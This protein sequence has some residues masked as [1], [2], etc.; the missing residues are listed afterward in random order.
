MSLSNYKVVPYI[1]TTNL[2]VQLYLV[3]LAKAEAL[4]LSTKFGKRL[5][6]INQI[7]RRYENQHPKVVSSI[8]RLRNEIKLLGKGMPDRE[9]IAVASGV[10]L[11]GQQFPSYKGRVTRQ[12][13]VQRGFRKL[14]QTYHP[15]K[16][17]SVEQFN[18]LMVARE[19]LDLDWINQHLVLQVLGSSIAWQLEQGLPFWKLQTQRYQVRFDRIAE[20]PAFNVVQLHMVGRTAEASSTMLSILEK[21]VVALTA[22][23][24]ASIQQ[25]FNHG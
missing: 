3:S 17:G 9:G 14:A 11:L 1:D 13:L 10:D 22:E 2:I 15:D 5:S 19:T 16:G 8:A 12:Y 20:L 24:H 4:K 7:I 18:A 21:T 6:V 25:E 23:Y